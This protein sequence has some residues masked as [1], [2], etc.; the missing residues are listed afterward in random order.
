[1]RKIPSKIVELRDVDD[2]NSV[3]DDNNDWDAMLL[4]Q[5]MQPYDMLQVL[6]RKIVIMMIMMMMINDPDDDAVLLVQVVQSYDMLQVLLR[7][8]VIMMIMMMMINDPDVDAVLLV[9]VMQSYDMLHVSP[10]M[11]TPPVLG[12]NKDLSDEAGFLAV[13][14]ET[15]QHVR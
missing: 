8:I 5:V 3:P 4:V 12:E 15:L 10:P 7:K 14:K 6:L 1:M 2:V 11:N 13:N 9:Q